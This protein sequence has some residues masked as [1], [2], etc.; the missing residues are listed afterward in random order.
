MSFRAVADGVESCRLRYGH[1]FIQRWQSTTPYRN[2]PDPSA[3]LGVTGLIR[4]R[5]AT[6]TAGWGHPAAP[7]RL[8]PRTPQSAALPVKNRLISPARCAILVPRCGYNSSVECDLPKVDRWVRLPLPAPARRKLRIA[9][10]EFFVS[11]KLIVRSLR[12]SSLPNRT[13][14]RWASIWWDVI[15]GTCSF[16]V[17]TKQLGASFLSLAPLLL[18]SK[19]DPLAL[20]SHL[21]GRERRDV[22]LPR[23]AQ[24]PPPGWEAAVFSPPAQKKGPRPGPLCRLF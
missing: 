4:R 9:Y 21:V 13:R 19:C 7:A 1:V 15:G 20:G 8:F 10:D 3:V 14:L 5:H 16:S 6:G 22:Q 2:R 18:A 11:K 23:N 17:N 12:Y 24:P